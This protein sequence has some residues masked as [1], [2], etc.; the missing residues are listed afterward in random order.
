MTKKILFQIPIFSSG[1]TFVQAFFRIILLL[2][3]LQ[4]IHTPLVANDNLY[5]VPYIQNFTPAE[6][7]GE[8]Q[9][10]CMV[11][12]DKGVNFF[13]NQNGILVYNKFA[14]TNVHIPG[15][16]CFDITPSGIIYVGGFNE[17]GYLEHGKQEPEY[18]SL[19]QEFLKKEEFGLVINVVTVGE[20]VLFE[21]SDKLYFFHHEYVQVIDTKL[22]P[23]VVFKTNNKVFMNHSSKGLCLFEDNRVVAIPGGLEFLSKNILD[24]FFWQ[25]SFFIKV[26]D[27]SQFYRYDGSAV[28]SVEM[29]IDSYFL[30]HP[31]SH[32]IA[33]KDGELAVGTRGNGIFIFDNNQQLR[34]HLNK[35]SGLQDEYV[36]TLFAD[37]FGN[38]WACLRNGISR[39]EYPS[40]SS[41]FNMKTN[42]E[43]GVFA[44]IRNQ[45]MLYVATDNGVFLR[46]ESRILEEKQSFRP[47]NLNV[48]VAYQF[49]SMNHQLF[50]SSSKGI[51]KLQDDACEKVYGRPSRIS[52]AVND[53]MLVSGWDGIIEILSFRENGFVH[54]ASEKINGR[55]QYIQQAENGDIW[56][57]T[58]YYGLFRLKIQSFQP[59]LYSFEKFTSTEQIPPGHGLIQL[60]KSKGKV[61]FISELGLL[62]FQD[63][64]KTFTLDD[65][66]YNRLGVD[67]NLIH[68]IKCDNLGNFYL[69]IK[70]PEGKEFTVLKT[71]QNQYGKFESFRHITIRDLN[72]FAVESVYYDRDETLWFCGAEGLIQ[73]DLGFVPEIS[74]M[75]LIFTSLRVDLDTTFFIP[76]EYSFTNHKKDFFTIDYWNNLVNIS[77]VCPSYFPGTDVLY[78]YI[79]E[80][81]EQD[82]SE[83]SEKTSKEYN[84]LN[85]GRYIFR[86]RVKDVIK[87]Q[88]EDTELGI[89]I[90][91]PW[92]MT[93]IAYASYLI[94]LLSFIWM[95][96][97]IR[98]YYYAKDKIELERQIKEKTDDLVKEIERS[99]DLLLNMLPQ[100]IARQLKLFG[101]IPT[102]K[103]D[104]VSVMFMDIQGFSDIAERVDPDYLVKTL[105]R[106]FLGVD[107]II[108]TYN[109]EK[110]KTIGDGYMCAGGVP[111]KNRTNP[112]EVVL[113]ALEVQHYIKQL[114][115]EYSRLN[116]LHWGLRIGI[117]TGPVIAGVIGDKKLSYDIW[118]VTVN[119]ASRM[120]SNGM[121]GEIVLSQVT[122][123][124][125]KNYFETEYYGSLSLRSGKITEMYFVKGLKPAFRSGPLP[126]AFNQLLRFEL[127]EL[128]YLDLYEWVITKLEKELDSSLYYHNV[129][130]TVD[131]VSATRRLCREEQLDAESDLLVRTAALL[132][133]IGFITDYDNHE[134]QSVK[135]AK[136]ILPGYHYNLPQIE[137][138]CELIMATHYPPNPSNHLEEILCDADLDYLGRRDFVNG[139]KNLFMELYQRKK[140]KSVD[141]WIKTQIAFI[142]SHTY[143]TNSAIRAREVNKIQQLENLRTM[144]FLS[145]FF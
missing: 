59:L 48:G 86:V 25:N 21:T 67:R 78:S 144:D 118:G 74:H 36:N 19:N 137:K 11:Q 135:I 124:L 69:F 99:E 10:V 53:S 68:T 39:I 46:N 47:I 113:A 83:W 114:D 58:S 6:Y 107:G 105:D 14:W 140:I 28:S 134:L 79:L 110:I 45:S 54:R 75:P 12:N 34:M 84:N 66:I 49:L 73:Y 136:D 138:I 100:E 139:S 64:S 1:R 121:A 30:N 65:G 120:E 38:L 51:F 3:L 4:R 85:P 87:N 20:N 60:E 43:G 117:H 109:I 62:N 141:E 142:E 70:K 119:S 88:V 132:H 116:N 97:K 77:F 16:P 71:N 89:L 32:A 129:L 50:V 29:A 23:Q 145:G 9:N 91:P 7:G 57:S 56:L 127:A 125:V 143:F 81:H 17:F 18:H 108:S 92:Y 80:N 115:F 37:S 128:R 103:Y 22:V 95:T 94:L 93:K 5:G 122:H 42:F 13:G 96:I 44:V 123:E 111:V 41:F 90:R 101:K 102:T 2:I 98:S 82:W 15:Q 26:E 33:L 27:D 8:R 104:L 52:L 126:Y 133:D 31:F 55:V 61:Y 131:V 40:S 76:Q 130:H 72:N 35:L 63:S 106:F 112:V 24:I